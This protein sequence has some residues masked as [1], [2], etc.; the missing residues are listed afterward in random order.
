MKKLLLLFL[1]FL[2]V[3]CAPPIHDVRLS[4]SV[5]IT[6]TGNEKIY[7]IIRNPSG[8]EDFDLRTP[9]E[10]R[11][12]ARGYQL[13]NKREEADLTIH[14]VI[15]YCGL[16]K[17]AFTGV[18]AAAGA[19]AGF[20]AGAAAGYSA[21]GSGSEA[22]GG[23]LAGAAVGALIGAAVEENARQT[24]FIGIVDINIKE[25]DSPFPNLTSINAT[26]R[27]PLMTYEKA[28]DM[29]KDRLADKIIN[30]L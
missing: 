20:H 27:E 1:L 8:L 14:V 5:F 17:D 22:A 29:L 16:A 11:L 13:V 23:A 19:H 26:L 10:Y 15:R 12:A 24:T 28:I 4:K 7:L 6:T 18:G 25:K 21:H 2:I 3:G 9:M 30:L